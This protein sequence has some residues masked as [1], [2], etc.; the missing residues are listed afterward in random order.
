MI[1]EYKLCSNDLDIIIYQY[2]LS[3][4]I[5]T[6]YQNELSAPTVISIKSLNQII[7]EM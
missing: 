5:I 2:S 7:S 1:L 3:V 6:N 4:K